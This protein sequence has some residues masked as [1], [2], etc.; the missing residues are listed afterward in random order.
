MSKFRGLAQPCLY[1]FRA[2]AI[3]DL[4]S[5]MV[6]HMFI[7]VSAIL[8]QLNVPLLEPTKTVNDNVYGVAN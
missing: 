5:K 1:Q 8:L 3:D 6:R 2:M 7:S 4:K